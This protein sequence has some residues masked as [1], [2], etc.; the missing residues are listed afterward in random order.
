MCDLWDLQCQAGET[1]AGI[2]GTV[3]AT[4][5]A[6]LTA[7]V[8]DS[9]SALIVATT[10]W[11]LHL[12]TTDVG[13]SPTARTLQEWM[14]PFAA[15]VAV[16]GMFWQSLLMIIN[17]KG[18]P[19]LTVVKGLFATAVWGAVAITGTQLLLDACQNYTEWVLTRGL[20]CDPGIGQDAACK[21]DALAERLTL[22]LA[23]APGLAGIIA[24]VGGFLVLIAGLVQAV[25]LLFRNGAI[26]ILAGLLQL[27]A[28]GTFT[29]ATSNWLRRVLG[30]LL[31]L[32]FYQP[33]AATCYAVAFMLIG[34]RA[35]TDLSTWLTGVGML[36][37]SL[38]ALP[39]MMRF[40]TWTV[41]AVQSAGNPAGMLAAAGAAGLHAAASLRSPTSATSMAEY[42]RDLDRRYTP[43][44]SGGTSGSS[45]TGAP[46]PTP[47]VF[48]GPSPSGGASPAGAATGG[49]SPAAGAST[50]G[51]ATA[52]G[53]SAASGATTGSAATGAA[54]A[55]GPAGVVVT[56]VVAGAKG[57]AGA[58]RGAADT[59]VRGT[60]G[61]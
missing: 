49:A 27:A 21:T 53:T 12:P 38:V 20:G 58:A 26:I 32:V 4:M 45:G 14:L 6:H 51:G 42:T 59:A 46:R 61:R 36:A 3:A 35:N 25:L 30:W 13:T 56:G 15:L 17:R 31:A 19:L 28:A 44:P 43:N 57:A 29:A 24:L 60:E 41:G 9:L 2:T 48:T 40:F 39:A 52:G 5:V 47:P 16:G 8:S 33:F 10:T 34:D 50:A 23:P 54:A 55:A 7:M 22:M 1:A 18:E 11:W 37:L